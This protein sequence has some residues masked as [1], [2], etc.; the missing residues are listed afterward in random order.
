MCQEYILYVDAVTLCGGL[1]LE[2]SISGVYEFTSVIILAVT[3][4]TGV[5]MSSRFHKVYSTVYKA[6]DMEDWEIFGTTWMS[7]SLTHK[8]F[9][10]DYLINN[11]VLYKF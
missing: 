5:I 6:V 10:S 3:D 4:S 11:S 7:T 8:T 1:G 9:K 2:T